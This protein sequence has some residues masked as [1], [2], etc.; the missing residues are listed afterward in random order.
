[1]TNASVFAAASHKGFIRS[2]NE[3]DYLY[4]RS[5]DHKFTLLIVADG[6]GGHLCGEEASQIAVQQSSRVLDERFSP[7]MSD[8]EIHDLLVTSMETANIHVELESRSNPEKTGMGTTLS[9][10]IIVGNKL[11]LGH[12]GDS[13]IYLQRQREL[14]Q[15]TRDDTYVQYLIDQGMLD[16]SQRLLHPKRNILIKALGVPE[17]L[18]PQVKTQ[19]LKSRDKILFCTDGLYDCVT[20]DEINRILMTAQHPNAAVSELIEKALEYGAPDNVT[21]LV[22]YL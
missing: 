21:V 16:E 7:D 15:I 2:N 1:M 20:E 6:M 9:C 4:L 19:Q 8:I 22:G 17:Q 5:P 18:D 13:R 12:V 10:G 11:H 3:D 14:L